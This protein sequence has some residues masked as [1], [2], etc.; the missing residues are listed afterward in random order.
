VPITADDTRIST[1]FKSRHLQEGLEPSQGTELVTTPAVA[2]TETV[3]AK[4]EGKVFVCARCHSLRHYGRVKHPD[5]ERLLPDFDFVAAVSPCLA[6][7]YGA[8]SLVLLL[9]DASD[10]DGLFS[11]AVARLVA[12]AC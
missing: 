10:F 3:G 2:A 8:R 9:V 11:R 4:E 1:S 5:A 12:A 6:S 7:P